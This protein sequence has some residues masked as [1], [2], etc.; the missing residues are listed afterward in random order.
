MKTDKRI[1]S[2]ILIF[3]LFVA[4]GFSNNTNL[5]II[6]PSDKARILHVPGAVIK[7]MYT[8]SEKCQIQL[9]QRKI[10][11]QNIDVVGDELQ[12]GFPIKIRDMFQNSF[13]LTNINVI[14]GYFNKE[15]VTDNFDF[16]ISEQVNLRKFWDTIEFRKILAHVYDYNAVKANVT[17]SGWSLEK[18]DV[19]VQSIKNAKTLF[20]FRV[21]LQPGKNPFYLRIINDKNVEVAKD[22][23]YYF[24]PSELI[25]ESPGDEFVSNIFHTKANEDG[26][27]YCHEEIVTNECEECHSSILDHKT[28]HPILEEDDC[29]VCHDTDSS[30]RNQLLGDMR[31]D[32][33]YCLECHSD[34]EEAI[35]NTEFIH[36]PA[37][38]GCI[39]CHDAHASS[40]E[41]LTAIPVYDICSYCHEDM[42]NTPHPVPTHPISGGPDPS[43]PGK[44]LTCT[45]CHNPHG[46]DNR[47][48][49]YQE[50]YGICKKCHNK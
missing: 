46:S 34:I 32:P 15:K 48:L 50:G 3:L 45:S 40:L 1:I 5:Q 20:S 10:I 27:S 36:A 38:E 7:G 24:F 41:T 35:S 21:D 11:R 13:I 25:D 44:E 43:R 8:T 9:L 33:E 26:C 12:A 39:M 49:L 17:L 22:T 23:I 18:R 14:T 19:N 42:A 6:I 47:S 2:R 30:P 37:E 28:V 16:P 29:S 4:I 31:N